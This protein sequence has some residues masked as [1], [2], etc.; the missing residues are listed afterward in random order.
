MEYFH[1]L[2]LPTYVGIKGSEIAGEFLNNIEMIFDLL[3]CTS[4]EK[5]VLATYSFQ[6]E[7]D[8]RWECK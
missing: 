8:V 2:N 4:W 3:K 6:C 1:K 5:V 7:A